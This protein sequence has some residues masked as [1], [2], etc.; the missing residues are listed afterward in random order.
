M[1][2]TVRL[3]K[4]SEVK[5]ADTWDLSPLCQSDEEWEALFKKLDKQIA[6]YE[7]FRGKLGEGPKSLAACFKFDNDFDRLGERVGGYAHLKIT[8]DQADSAA[9]AM[10]AR[11]QNLATRASQA[12][13][14]I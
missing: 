3:P 6:G 5:T 13:S 12:A 4:R 9:Q 1:P 10:V 7:R 11:F 8:E 14:Y 2:K